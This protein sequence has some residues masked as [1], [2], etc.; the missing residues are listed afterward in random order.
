MLIAFSRRIYVINFLC[1]PHYNT[2]FRSFNA[3]KQFTS[4]VVINKVS[5]LAVKITI[6][7]SVVNK[8]QTFLAGIW[9]SAI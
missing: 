2:I 8:L 3:L 1:F 5:I 9:T 7:I 6:E 4:K